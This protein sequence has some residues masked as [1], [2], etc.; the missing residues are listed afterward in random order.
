M[1]FEAM[2][3]SPHSGWFFNLLA[4]LLHGERGTLSL[5]RTNPFP[6]APPRYVRAQ[7]YQYRFSTPDERRSTGLW[8]DRQLVRTFYGPISLARR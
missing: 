4:S 8:W 3:P 2:A 7:Y 1:W 6:N 5:L